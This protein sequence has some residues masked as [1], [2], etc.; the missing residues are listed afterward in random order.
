MPNPITKHFATL[1]MYFNVN[2]N[3]NPETAQEAIV[4]YANTLKP[5]KGFNSAVC[6]F[7]V[8]DVSKT[9]PKMKPNEYS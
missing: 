5:T 9:A 8:L 7:N 1:S 4:A 6:S 2:D 3:S